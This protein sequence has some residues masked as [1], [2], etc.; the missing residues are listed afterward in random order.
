[1]PSSD[2]PIAPYLVSA[3]FV[4]SAMGFMMRRAPAAVPAF[5]LDLG[6]EDESEPAD[7]EETLA[8]GTTKRHA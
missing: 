1:V 8:P 2:H 6:G 5:T 7:D 4:P 3:G